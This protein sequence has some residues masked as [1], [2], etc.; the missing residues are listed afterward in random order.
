MSPRW[1]NALTRKRGRPG[2]WKA[3]SSSPVLSK[4]ASR[5]GALGADLA[6]DVLEQR[7]VERR[8]ARERLEVAVEADDRRL[9]D[10]QVDVARAALDGGVQQLD[11]VPCG[12]FRQAV[13]RLWC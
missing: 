4:V 2:R 12:S 11:Q 1:R 9:A 10:L 6:Q 13:G 5:F 7:R 3:V 8:P